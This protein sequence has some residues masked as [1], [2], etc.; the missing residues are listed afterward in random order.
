MKIRIHTED[1]GTY[2]FRCE[3]EGCFEVTTVAILAV[4][5]IGVPIALLVKAVL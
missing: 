3:F 5:S 4:I 1:D 2:V